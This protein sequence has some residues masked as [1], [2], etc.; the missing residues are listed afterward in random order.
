MVIPTIA[1]QEEPV[2]Y[3]TKDKN[4]SII[5][6]WL[7]SNPLNPA[8]K[9][10]VVAA[11][12]IPKGTSSKGEIIPKSTVPRRGMLIEEV[13][14]LIAIK[15][16]DATAARINLHLFDKPPL[17]QSHKSSINPI[18]VKI[19]ITLRSANISITSLLYDFMTKVLTAM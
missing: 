14:T 17:L 4:D 12:T 6:P 11:P 5:I 18:M 3:A 8:R 19:R 13:P 16:I 2:L 10:Y 15:G 7:A 1:S 9:L